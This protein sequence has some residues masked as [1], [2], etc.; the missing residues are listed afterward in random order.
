L[1][2]LL[3][4]VRQLERLGV[5]KRELLLD[6]EGEVGAAVERVP[7]VRQQLL[8]RDALLVTHCAER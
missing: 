1:L 6:G 3:E 7:C 5:E 4:A 2:Q 8:P